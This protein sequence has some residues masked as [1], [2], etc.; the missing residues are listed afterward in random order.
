MEQK[1]DEEFAL[2][3]KIISSNPE[4]TVNS[5]ERELANIKIEDFEIEDEYDGL[6]EDETTIEAANSFDPGKYGEDESDSFIAASR[7]KTPDPEFITNEKPK[8]TRKS[9]AF[10]P[11]AI[12]IPSSVID[13]EDEYSP[14][15]LNRGFITNQGR[16]TV[17]FSDSEPWDSQNE[18]FTAPSFSTPTKEVAKPTSLMSKMFNFQFRKVQAEQEKAEKKEQNAFNELEKM[19]A[20]LE[21]EKQDVQVMKM[22]LA[23]ETKGTKLSLE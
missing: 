11:D 1:E 18:D 19:K 21:K 5:V 14:F 15:G 6:A 7:F 8:M 2:M 20:E 12:S 22:K 3:E 13:S 17:N 23:R 4:L 10:I 9:A 16:N